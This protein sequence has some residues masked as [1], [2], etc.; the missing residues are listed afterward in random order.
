MNSK[1]PA[2]SIERFYVAR[3]TTSTCYLSRAAAARYKSPH[4]L[5]FYAPAKTGRQYNIACYSRRQV[6]QL[7]L[8]SSGIAVGRGNLARL[9][10]SRS[11]CGKP[12]PNL[13]LLRSNG[14]TA[15][16]GRLQVDTGLSAAWRCEKSGDARSTSFSATARWRLRGRSNPRFSLNGHVVDRLWPARLD[17]E[18][19]QSL[20]RVDRL[21]DI[22]SRPDH[23][24]RDPE[25]VRCGSST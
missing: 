23:G 20:G 12:A 13:T 4:Y 8:F 22:F 9:G 14:P 5:T 10:N 16:A 24:R 7:G 17:H 6:T 25:T 21:I 19:S 15:F 11:M 1:D 2:R 18:I 3:A